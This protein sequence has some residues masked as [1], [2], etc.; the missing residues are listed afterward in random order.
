MPQQRYPTGLYGRVS[1]DDPRRV[2]I[3]IQ[4]T[5]LRQWAA[6]DPLAD[7]VEEY[8]DEGV[9]GAIPLRDRPAGRRIMEDARSGR[10]KV[11][12]VVYAD[13][14]GRDLLDGLQAVKELEAMGVK[15]VTIHEGWDA[16]R[17]DSP[18]YFQF[19]M[20]LA[21]EDRRRIRERMEGGKQ[22]AMARDNAPPGGPL[23]FG[24][25]MDERGHFVVDEVEGPIVVRLFEMA[26]EGYSQAQ[27]L[28]WVKSLPSAPPA[29]LKFQ[30]R[31]PG[32]APAVIR[33]Q[34]TAQWH[35]TKIG[36]IL[37][38]ET[39]TGQ[40]TWKGRTFPCPPLVDR[41][42]FDKVQALLAGTRAGMRA[43]RGNPEN[44]LVSGLFV[45]GHCGQRY[46]S[47]RHQ[48]KRRTGKVD[49]YRMYICNSV[50]CRKPGPDKCGAKLLAVSRVDADVW[51]LVKQFLSD[52]G[53]LVRKVVAADGGR[54]E[55]LAD[56]DAEQVRLQ[57]EVQAIDDKATQ[58]WRDQEA[59]GWPMAFVTERLN[60]LKARRESA[61]AQMDDV[62]RRR[63]ALGLTQ[64]EAER[65]S[66]ALAGL[67]AKLKANPSPAKKA[68]L[69]RLLVAGGVVHT[70]GKGTRKTAK[71]TVQFRWGDAVLTA[72]QSAVPSLPEHW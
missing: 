58:V 44:G 22:R 20:M 45:C 35:Q 43:N 55:E 54:R 23:I 28:A 32:S 5:T 59:H 3:E 1:K 25:R 68:E 39:Y 57:A 61:A 38:C 19:R 18:M 11:L 71:L 56:L 9:S 70:E 63:A 42:T 14:F 31:Q 60:R 16:R 10:L 46:Y 52:P 12:A 17:N 49:Y 7:V 51:G 48:S 30:K 40:R 4:Q 69:I 67:R 34:A 64:E 37:R 66:T 15:L 72:A 53:D 24:Y 8:W 13:R 33:T 62:R 50:R 21:E 2:T 26:L 41:E 47:Q 6:N 27:M 29:G 65:I 36:K